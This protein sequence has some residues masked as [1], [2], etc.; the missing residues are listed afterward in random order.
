MSEPWFEECLTGM[1]TY[2]IWYWTGMLPP[3][4]SSKGY[5]PIP[6]RKVCHVSTKLEPAQ[7]EGLLATRALAA[8]P[9]EVRKVFGAAA[10]PGMISF[11]G[12]SPFLGLLP[13]EQIAADAARIIAERGAEAFQY[14]ASQGIESL[15][16]HI[17]QI[18]QIEGICADKDEVIVSTG[19]Q[20]ALDTVARILINPGDVVLAEGPSYAGGMA[21]FSSYE[22][23]IIH[24]P[25]DRDGLIPE[26]LSRVIAQTRAAGKTIKGLYTI[27]N[28]QN[29][30]GTNLS[31]ERRMEVGQICRAEGLLIFEDNPYGLLGFEGQT[32][33]AIQPDFADITLY[34][35]SFS[36]MFA[37]GLRLGWVLAPQALRGYIINASETAQL[38]PSVLNQLIMSAYLDDPR[39]KD[40][41]KT[42]QGVYKEKFEALVQALELHMPE[43]TTWNVPDG[44]FY[45]WITL[46]KRL[47]ANALVGTCIERGAVYV[48]GV[49]FFTDDK[50]RNELRMSFCGPDPQSIARGVQ[51]V[52]QVF[53]EA[54][55]G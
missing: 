16:E 44:G 17:V 42:Y 29:P 50:G 47:D 48:P 45:C 3:R 40:T 37:P 24:V 30:G 41:L 27:P 15:R 5:H 55:A 39:W 7:L 19:S 25:S 43:G 31:A 54:L 18:M 28:F 20:Q 33:R 49:A 22:A 13:F 35:G 2:W 38:N 14:G 36:K 10:R 11:A 12:G 46:P 34:F 21:V 6:A 9:S 32:M 53:R 52:G 23:Q 4:H 51:I 26:E 1:K 8:R